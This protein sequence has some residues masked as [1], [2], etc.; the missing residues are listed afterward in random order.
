MT[1]GELFLVAGSF[2]INGGSS[3]GLSAEFSED[4]FSLVEEFEGSTST[5][6]F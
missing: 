3:L 6:F 1:S 4:D 5:F 2:A